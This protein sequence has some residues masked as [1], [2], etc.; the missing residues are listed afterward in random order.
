MDNPSGKGRS[1]TTGVSYFAQKASRGFNELLGRGKGEATVSH[2]QV[3]GK[4]HPSWTQ[5]GLLASPEQRQQPQA[6]HQGYVDPGYAA[7]D[8]S[9]YAGQSGTWN[10]P[11]STDGAQT[12]AS[13]G[14]CSGCP[15]AVVTAPGPRWTWRGDRA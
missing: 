4:A 3:G 9:G 13:A 7:D 15:A 6:Q 1:G 11:S 8:Y 14:Q 2:D 12:Y 10:V 5:G